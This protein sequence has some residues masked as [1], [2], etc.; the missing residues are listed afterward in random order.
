MFQEQNSLNGFLSVGGL[1][2]QLIE[3]VLCFGPRWLSH[4]PNGFQLG[5]CVCIKS[6][7]GK[8]AAK[9]NHLAR[10]S[11]RGGVSRSRPSRTLENLLGDY[12]GGLGQSQ[13]TNDNCH[14]A[15]GPDTAALSRVYLQEERC[16]WPCHTASITGRLRSS[17][18]P[19]RGWKLVC[20]WADELF[21]SC[22]RSCKSLCE[23]GNQFNKL[24]E[25]KKEKPRRRQSPVVTSEIEDEHERE[26]QRS[27]FTDSPKNLLQITLRAN[28]DLNRPTL[29]LPLS[30][31]FTTPSTIKAKERHAHSYPAETPLGMCSCGSA[32][33]RSMLLLL[34]ARASFLLSVFAGW[35]TDAVAAV[36]KRHVR[37]RVRVLHVR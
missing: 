22:S 28:I 35:Q 29:L 4:G 19:A 11:H 37:L 10:P 33:R 25:D 26:L 5:L 20:N 9:S 21:F 6:S 7:S 8:V 14:Y 1:L 36:A 31:E 24:R 17:T 3:L 23:R 18:A 27:P 15:P 16:E 34:D 2:H 13:Q 30:P 32:A 12:R